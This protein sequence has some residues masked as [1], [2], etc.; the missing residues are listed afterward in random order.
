MRRKE[1]GAEYDLNL[2]IEILVHRVDASHLLWVAAQ[3]TSHCVPPTG[4]QHL[5]NRGTQDLVKIAPRSTQGTV[6]GSAT[7][8]AMI[9][10]P[11]QQQGIQG[12]G[13]GGS[14]GQS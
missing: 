7:Q 6:D 9:F 10:P 13:V 4:R 11:A 5:V 2:I 8:L 3:D 14:L 1:A 12:T